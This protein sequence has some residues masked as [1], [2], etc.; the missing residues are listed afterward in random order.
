MYNIYTKLRNADVAQ[1]ARVPA[2]NLS[3][4]GVMVALQTST[5]SVRVRIPYT[6]PTK[7]RS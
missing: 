6:G 4:I 5:L 1:L 3:S 7:Y 2:Y